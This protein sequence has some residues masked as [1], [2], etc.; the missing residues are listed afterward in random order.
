MHTTS[1]FIRRHIYLLPEGKLFSTRLFLSYGKRAAIDQ[2]LYRLVKAERIIRVT[3]GLFVKWSPKVSMPSL[4]EVAKAKAEAFG[5]EI[6][7]C[8]RDAAKHLG[9]IQNTKLLDFIQN[10]TNQPIFAVSGKTSSFQYGDKRIT[11]KGISAKYLKLGDSFAGKT[12]R[13]L[14]YL[15]KQINCAEVLDK[16]TLFIN[17]EN[18]QELRRSTKH[19]PA[20]MSDELVGKRPRWDININLQLA[21]C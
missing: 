20:W 11:L 16:A 5:K 13:G 6:Y 18:K 14:L 12:I 19:M 9:L 2:C 1:T 17:R 10:E 8:G 3:R 4:Y 21:P 7:T 15:G